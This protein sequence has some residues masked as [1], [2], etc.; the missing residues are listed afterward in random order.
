[1][2][3]MPAEESASLRL[4]NN[5]CREIANDLDWPM[6]PIYGH[7]QTDSFTGVRGMLLAEL[8][9][10]NYTLEDLGHS[11][12]NLGRL[13]PHV[14]REMAI[15]YATLDQLLQPKEIAARP[16]PPLE[17]DLTADRMCDVRKVKAAPAIDGSLTDACW[18]TI[19]AIADLRPVSRRARP[20]EGGEVRICYDDENLYLAFSVPRERAPTSEPAED[21]SASPDSPMIEFMLDTN[22]NR[23]S[24]F[25]FR[26]NR[27][28]SLECRYVPVPWVPQSSADV[29]G[30]E[31][32]VSLAD[33]T[34]EVSVPLS[35][36]SS[37]GLVDAPLDL[38]LPEGSVW[39][40]NFVMTAQPAGA[41]V[42]W[43]AI[44]SRTGHLPAEFNAI[45]FAGRDQQ[46]AASK[47]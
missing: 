7:Y 22:Y 19:A 38:P 36:L 34:A 47:E 6:Y 40:A 29:S 2:D 30:C 41:E 32:A 14:V 24:C 33:G 1:M 46:E 18:K 4:V 43:S 11:T 17:C 12:Y 44:R 39:G 37:D 45:R 8:H 3:L 21:V 23:W 9:I 28:G 42:S 20:S 25:Y 15:Y 13:M 16:R 31:V 27:G 10:P 5:M 26:L 35:I